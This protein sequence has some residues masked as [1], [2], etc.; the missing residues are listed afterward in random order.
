MGTPNVDTIFALASGA[1][2]AGIAVYRISGPGAG[3][4]FTALTGRAL[5]E[6]RHAVRIRVGKD[7]SGDIIDDGIGLWF[8]AP[9]SFTGE[10]VAE[11]HLH[12]GPAVM[13][14]VTEAL[15]AIDG[16]R[17]AEPGEFSRR[18]F[19][20]GKF[21]L[22][23]AEGLADLVNAE[24]ESQRRQARRQFD[25]ALTAVFEDWRT[26]L[27]A[28]LAGAE[29]A[30]DFI[31]EDDVPADLMATMNHKISGIID[32]ITQYLDDDHRGERLRDGIYIAILGAP[33]VG[34]SSLLNVL[35]RRQAAIV[36]EIAGTTRDVIEVHL[37]MGGVPVIVADTAGLGEAGDEIEG[38]GIRRARARAADADVKLALFDAQS[39]PRMDDATSSLVDGDTVVVVN[40][41]D[42]CDPSRGSLGPLSHEDRPVQVISV[43][44]GDGMADLVHRI[45]T[46]VTGRIETA[47]PPAL[48]RAR[49]RAALEDCAQALKRC[50][51][52]DAAELVA[53]DLRLAA[54]ALGR[55]TG[56]IDVEDVLDAIFKEFCIGK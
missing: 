21:D 24:T 36:S 14:A 26:R 43:L 17:L 45:E 15:G 52:A 42:L 22:T 34:K 54:R 56:R 28:A 53:E 12:G 31:D 39:W 6:P 10:D 4:A 19:E 1:G 2:R 18:A 5:P 44:R 35:A 29:A 50:Q 8:T 40:K 47:G 23:Q 13:A 16:L 30:I 46:E 51:A 7:V 3:A 9:E 11:L 38:E 33:N 41:A 20:N 55:I 49:H 27:I 32:E 48:T 25:G 37:N